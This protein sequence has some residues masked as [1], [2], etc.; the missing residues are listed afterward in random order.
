MDIYNSKQYKISRIAYMAHAAFNYF[1]SLV[2]VDVFL[3]NLL[4]H[5]GVSDSLIG[6]IGS[7]A[8]FAFLFQLLSI[9]IVR[10]LRGAKIFSMTM[11]TI[12]QI[13]FAL[14]YMLPM[15]AI[16]QEM[17]IV[18]TML[19]I[20]ISY[21]ANQLVAGMIYNWA[22]LYVDPRARGVFSAKNEMISLGGGVIF[23]YIMGLVVDYYESIGNA[24]GGFSF[25]AATILSLSL[26]SFVSLMLIKNDKN[27]EKISTQ[28]DSFGEVL[29][30]TF[31]NKGFV[32][33]MI[34]GILYQIGMGV[35]GGFLGTFKTIDLA[36]SIS[37]VQLIN[38]AGCI[39][40][41]C[42]SIPFGKFSD[43][44]S[45]ATGLKLGFALCCVGYFALV[46]ATPKTWWLIIIFTILINVSYAGTVGNS[47]N[48][49]YS[50]VDKK[51]V[52]QAMAIKNSTSGIGNFC[53]ALVGGKILSSI[54]ANSNMVFG[55]YIY[56]Q[57]ILAAISTVILLL[58][59]VFIHFVVEKKQAKQ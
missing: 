18:L 50:C 15:T 59:V 52:V 38:N 53:A 46:F 2:V 27:S 23:A 28:Q 8:Q 20:L 48:I 33:V 25:L 6:V 31:G 17:K 36:I 51:Y 41:A 1:V 24:Y 45:Y 16:G 49:I 5:M 58:C 29:K 10:K 21:A 40:R 34:V 54:Q 4:N 3:S 42:I 35:T 44:Y 37:A 19:C 13:L 12:S 57:Q 22:Y 43:K 55:H 14:L 30:N 26:L 47:N 56:G 32:S 9:F 7:I 11:V 39:I